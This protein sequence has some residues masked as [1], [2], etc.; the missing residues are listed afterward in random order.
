MGNWLYA[1]IDFYQTTLHFH[2]HM[3]HKLFAYFKI[4]ANYTRKYKFACVMEY[5]AKHR[6]AISTQTHLAPENRTATWDTCHDD[7]YNRFLKDRTLHLCNLCNEYGH[8][9]HACPQRTVE[10]PASHNTT[11]QQV[12]NALTASQTSRPHS[13][14]P[15]QTTNYRHQQTRPTAGTGSPI[16]T[17]PPST[18][19]M[20]RYCFRFNNGQYCAKPPCTYK[21]ACNLCFRTSHTASTCPGGSTF[22]P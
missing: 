14:F 7:Y 12:P 4:I 17:I 19:S 2:P 13:L 22:R 8:F 6:L 3:H 15:L 5:D 9:Q 21:H 11:N 16:P 20:S 10:L 1:W 18:P